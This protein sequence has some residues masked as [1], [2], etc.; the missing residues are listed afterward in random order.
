MAD[1]APSINF[2][3]ANCDIVQKIVGKVANLRDE[4]LAADKAI[5]NT[6]YD[7]AGLA[8]KY[9]DDITA[10]AEL[11]VSIEKFAEVSSLSPDAFPSLLAWLGTRY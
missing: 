11:P 1:L 6:K 10:L 7:A 3:Y 9:K 2:P 5:A 4:S 8:T